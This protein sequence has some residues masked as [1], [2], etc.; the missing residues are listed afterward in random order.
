MKS[1]ILAN[2]ASYIAIVMLLLTGSMSA[3]AQEQTKP[4]FFVEF[5]AGPGSIHVDK[6]ITSTE[7]RDVDLR[8]WYARLSPSVGFQFNNRWAAGVR[9]TADTRKVKNTSLSAKRVEYTGFTQYNFLD[10][11]R[12]SMCV[13][14]KVSYSHDYYKY[15][16][17]DYGEIG[18][19]LGGRYAI[20]DHFSIVAR[21][22]YTGL[23]LGDF[24]SYNDNLGCV[25]RGRYRLDFGLNRLQIGARYTF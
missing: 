16:Q 19:S 18:F 6:V 11:D 21:Y 24:R 7:I 20:N 5:T 23:T 4:R 9:V 2:V 10:R 13:E 1:K 3:V 22:L 12:W 17:N 15:P 8:E 14:G 25:G